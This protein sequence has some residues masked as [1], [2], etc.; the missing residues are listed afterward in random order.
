MFGARNHIAGESV[1][2]K[3]ASACYG[4]SIDLCDDTFVK[5]KILRIRLKMIMTVPAKPE[6]VILKQ[7]DRMTHVLVSAELYAQAA[8]FFIYVHV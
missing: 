8:Y 7:Y 2:V 3:T 6:I 5:C 4:R 1:K